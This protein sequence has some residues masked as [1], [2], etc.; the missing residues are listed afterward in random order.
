MAAI[1]NANPLIALDA[2]VIDSETT[3][4]DP[5]R[6]RIVEIAGVRL[7]GGRVDPPASFR[8]LVNPGEPIPAE[9][10]AVHHIDDAKVAAAPAFA[11]IWP[12]LTA[13]IGSAVVI[14]HTLG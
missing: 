7:T 6:A 13:F 10:V 8:H 11:E 5:R 3:G 4:L 12:E 2:V 9:A 1:G 14:G